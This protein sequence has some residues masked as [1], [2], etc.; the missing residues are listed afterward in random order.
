VRGG[1]VFIT[2]WKTSVLLPAVL[3]MAMKQP[4]GEWRSEYSGR[5]GKCYPRIRF[6]AA[7]P[8]LSSIARIGLA[9]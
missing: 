2:V 4:F 1:W 7:A 5:V 9:G 3:M 8:D 6:S